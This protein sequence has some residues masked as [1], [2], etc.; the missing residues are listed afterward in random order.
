MNHKIPIKNR[1]LWSEE[2][3]VQRSEDIICFAK[4]RWDTVYKTPEGSS[5]KGRG[6]S[7]KMWQRLLWSPAKT[8]SPPFPSVKTDFGG[9]INVPRKKHISFFPCKQGWPRRGK[10]K[11]FNEKAS[12]KSL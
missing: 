2:R 3:A 11:L 1:K 8:H 10:Q 6:T 4:L 12:R 9:G 5:R 7:S